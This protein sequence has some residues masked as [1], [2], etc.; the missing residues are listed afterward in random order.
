ML[1]VAVPLFGDQVA[2][3][4]GFSERFLIADI[5]NGLVVREE[6]HEITGPGWRE[7]IVELGRMGVK[8]ILSGGYSLQSLPFAESK[9]IHVIDDIWGDA[10]HAIELFARETRWLKRTAD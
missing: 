5:E 9:G 2:P 3:R 7:R 6:Q 4:F 1:R 10:S 8:V